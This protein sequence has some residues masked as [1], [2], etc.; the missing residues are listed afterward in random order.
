MPQNENQCIL[1]LANIVAAEQ[2]LKDLLQKE[3]LPLPI[4]ENKYG[5]VVVADVVLTI[6]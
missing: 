4:L 5:E 6:E 3:G 1:T 2:F